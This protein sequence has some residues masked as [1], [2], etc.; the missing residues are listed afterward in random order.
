MFITLDEL[1][2]FMLVLIGIVG[3]ILMGKNRK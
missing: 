3:L 2:S 1:C